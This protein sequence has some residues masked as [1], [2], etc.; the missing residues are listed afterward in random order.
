[1]RMK[2]G[3]LAL[4]TV[5]LILSLSFMGCGTDQKN[6]QQEAPPPSTGSNNQTPPANPSGQTNDNNT[7]NDAN[8]VALKDGKY[9]AE[10]ETDERGW[11]PFIE[12]TVTNGKITEAIYDEK[13]DDGDLKSKD[14]D[15]NKNW[16]EK[17]GVSAKEA[18]STLAQDLIKKQD[19][20]QV[21]TV[22]GATSASEKFVNLAKKALN[23][24]K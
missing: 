4:L 18:Y 11:T 9:E 12:I 5:L 15:Y 3:T 7:N 20:D 8:E 6:Q 23:Q 13:E 22:T 1:M 14:D 10:G 2:K 21:E 16:K 24:N 19:P 17:S